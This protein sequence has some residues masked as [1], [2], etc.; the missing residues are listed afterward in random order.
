M[1]AVCFH[2]CL[3]HNWYFAALSFMNIIYWQSNL[4][5]SMNFDETIAEINLK[6]KSTDSGC[7]RKETSKTEKER[8]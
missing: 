4:L 2:S 7:P 6:L 3:I 8:R 1:C 5:F